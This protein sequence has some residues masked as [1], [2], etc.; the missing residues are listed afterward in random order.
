MEHALAIANPRMV[1][2]PRSEGPPVTPP[3]P[4]SYSAKASSVS[5]DTLAVFG[6]ISI[7][8][9]PKWPSR[10]E[11]LEVFVKFRPGLRGGERHGNPWV[12]EDESV[13]VRGAGDRKPVRVPWCPPQKRSPA[14][15]GVGD[16]GQSELVA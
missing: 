6:E 1:S 9:V 5:P 14:E 16:D 7:L 15:C 12:L 4:S 8:V 3:L 2:G 11:D 13:P 10:F